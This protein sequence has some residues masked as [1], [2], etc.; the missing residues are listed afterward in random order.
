MNASNPALLNSEGRSLNGKAY[1][2]T[3][4][5]NL[6]SKEDV[7]NFDIENIWKEMEEIGRSKKA[8]DGLF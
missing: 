2:S 8:A 1:R 7:M 6:K 3:A 5:I 4:S